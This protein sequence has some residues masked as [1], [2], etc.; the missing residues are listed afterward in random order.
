MSHR[1]YL[2]FLLGAASALILFPAARNHY[3]VQ[4]PARESWAIQARG[5]GPTPSLTS[6]VKDE[7]RT[8]G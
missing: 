7:A 2:F 5:N 8:D 1:E 4:M 3:H 6:A